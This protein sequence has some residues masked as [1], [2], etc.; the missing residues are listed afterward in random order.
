M[1]I[2]FFYQVIYLLAGLSFVHLFLSGNNIV[3]KDISNL[4]DNSNIIYQKYQFILNLAP[5][6]VAAFASF[7]IVKSI[8]KYFSD[9]QQTKLIELIKSQTKD[10]I[11]E[12]KVLIKDLAERFDNFERHKD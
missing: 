4:N 3:T 11:H 9:K 12:L 2:S 6:M 8:S 10:D 5:S 7:Q 1:E